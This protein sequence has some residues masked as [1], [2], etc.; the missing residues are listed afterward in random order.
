MVNRVTVTHNDEQTVVD[1]CVKNDIDILN[2]KV[3]EV[4]MAAF[5]DTIFSP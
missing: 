5:K 2:S 4:C 1:Y 3:Y